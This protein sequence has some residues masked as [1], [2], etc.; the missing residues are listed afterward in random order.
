MNGSTRKKSVTGSIKNIANRKSTNTRGKNTTIS[1]ASFQGQV[2]K[3]PFSA[4]SP[5]Q[6]FRN[7]TVNSA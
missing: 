4:L 7:H 1:P 6:L 2:Y 3:L 5:T